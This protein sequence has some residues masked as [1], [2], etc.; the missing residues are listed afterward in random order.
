MNESSPVLAIDTSGATGWVAL[1]ALSQET[2]AVTCLHQVEL[3]VR[4]SAA[5]L[6]P[7]ILQLLQQAE[8]ALAALRAIVV[9]HGPG[10]FTGL[11]VALSTAKGLAHASGVPLAEVSRLAVLAALSQSPECLALLDAGRGELYAGEYRDRVCRR[12][13]LAS[14]GEVEE[15]ARN[16]GRL[17]VAEDAVASRLS[18]WSPELAGPLDAC[19]AV[20]TARERLL[21]GDW[22]DLRALDAN[23]LRHSDAQLFARAA[24]GRA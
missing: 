1:A 9:V 19:A 8:L 4:A 2:E 11:R 18:H 10:S 17:V 7:A 20:R 23:Y 3:G 24:A 13:W 21:A 14:L 5:Q 12:E 22:D 15:Y 16:G 6:M